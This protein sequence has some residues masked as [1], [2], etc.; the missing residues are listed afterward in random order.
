MKK[1]K[2]LIGSILILAAVFC[3]IGLFFMKK[4][5]HD[6]SIQYVQTRSLGYTPKPI[7]IRSV[8]ELK[9]YYESNKEDGTL[10]SDYHADLFWKACEKYDKNYFKKQIL[11]LIAIG[12]PSISY[13]HEV[14]DVFLNSEQKLEINLNTIK[15][16]LCDLEAGGWHIF[17][18][19]AKGIKIDSEDDIKIV[20]RNINT[21][22]PLSS[23]FGVMQMNL[24][25]GQKIFVFHSTEELST[26]CNEYV[27][28]GKRIS[29]EHA[30]AY[31]SICDNFDESYFKNR[32]LVLVWLTEPYSPSAH[33]VTEVFFNEERE[34][35]I[36]I[37]T[38]T[39][40]NLQKTT[41][42]HLFISPA[43]G[44]SVEDIDD[45]TVVLNNEVMTFQ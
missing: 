11:V 40:G 5:N 1:K 43:K 20:R 24:A 25:T 41:G 13:S 29:T 33:E 23:D 6:F 16:E 31:K 44:V 21:K 32:I 4:E 34:L 17:V 7:L 35:E 28:D 19:P 45:I 8:E 14:T 37:S 18:E 36:R 27:G 30:L 42:E 39:L 2:M 9:F 12:E 10:K 3:V 38:T 26:Y 22:A 15:P